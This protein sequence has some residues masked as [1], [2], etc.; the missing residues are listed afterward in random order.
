MAAK[1]PVAKKAVAKKAAPKKAL[2]K[3]PVA[4]LNIVGKSPKRLDS[5]EKATGITRYVD[6]LTVDGM[7]IAYVVTSPWAHAILESVD[8][9]KA[10]K[11]KGI[12]AVLTAENLG[13]TNEISVAFGD[14]PLLATD[15]LRSF[16]DRVAIIA[17]ESREDAKAA[18]K[19]I[20]IKGKEL[21][22]VFDPLSALKK[23][24]PKIHKKGNIAAHQVVRKGDIEKAK[25]LAKF[26]IKR[27]F[28]TN[29]QEHAYLETQ[30]MIAFPETEGEVV[31]KGSMQCPYYI[32]KAIA[33]LLSLS[34]NQVRVIQTPT[35][36]AFGG[37]E[38][39]PSEVAGVAAVLARETGRPVKLI[40]TREEDMAWSS[41][42]HR[43]TL[44]HTIYA[45]K[46]GRLLGI[47]AKNYFDAG[48][49][50]GLTPIV[51]ER[52]N[53]ST[54]LPYLIPHVQ[55][56]TMSVYT[57][58][59]FGGAFRGFGA[60]QVTFA[61]EQLMDE[62]AAEVGVSPL[63]IRRINFLKT[64]DRLP[65][66]IVLRDDVWAQESQDL[67]VKRARFEA[68]Q[69]TYQKENA[70]NPEILKGIGIAAMSYGCCLHAGGQHLEGSG[71]LVQVHPDGSVSVSIGG[72]E[73]GQGA[74]SA[75]AQ[76]AA[77]GLGV[78]Y[79][80]V[81]VRPTDTATVPD[82][83]PT[84]ASRTTV[85]SGNAVVDACSRIY[86][87][88]LAVAAKELGVNKN[89]VELKGGK[90]FVDGKRRKMSVDTL[91][92]TAYLQ[93][94]TLTE[95]G[96]YA[97]PAKKWDRKTGNGEAYAVYAY[98]SMIAE[99][100]VDTLT[101]QVKV[102]KMTAVHDVG[103]AIS[104]EG[105]VAQVH[106]GVVQGMGWAIMENMVLDH[107]KILNPNFTDYQIPT[108]MDVPEIDVALIEEAYE[109]G[110]YGA[111]GIGEPSLIPVAAAIANA[112]AD[113][114]GTRIYDLPLTPERVKMAMDNQ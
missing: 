46:D 57:N 55:V 83:G 8:V 62:L 105:T 11:A 73:I 33:N 29:Y 50:A 51:S 37:K 43:T 91:I 39:Y 76:I 25:K 98:A 22:G 40:Y 45:R 102:D 32:Q 19:L 101:G 99:V 108:A 86:P 1:K 71:A 66:N 34:Q 58:N 2:R 80:R 10:R 18:A 77:E 42:R 7:L 61:L 106:G 81:R 15:K 64:G 20:T 5:Y 78:D 23:G 56:D 74:F 6:D 72:A 24:A 103:K 93:K 26:V 109:D 110:P 3:K 75:M 82:S 69:K 60:P 30:G 14:Q 90:I 36:G 79:E 44:H 113:A 12:H 49:Y 100:S 41:K 107:G 89:K 95:S 16:A 84:V 53:S 31:I 38:D 111:K 52:G 9:S 114:T 35:G 94:V 54:G 67:A 17:A 21:K 96:W 70:K 27:E 112:V 28:T 4:S 85:M 59:A 47:E 92:A 104:Y 87:R 65:T 48:G 13:E 63:E 97:P 88:L 68:K